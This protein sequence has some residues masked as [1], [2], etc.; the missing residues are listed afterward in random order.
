MASNVES[1]DAALRASLTA[2]SVTPSISTHLAAAEQY[3]RLGIL[4]RAVEHLQSG[5][6]LQPHNAAVNDALARVWRDFGLP[7]MGLSHAY[8][9]VYAEPRSATAR[10]TLG[11]LLYALGKRADAERAFRD[12]VDLD[13][14]AWYAWQNLCQ[15]AM[16]GG[17][18]QEAIDL[19]HHAIKLRRD[20]AK[21]NRP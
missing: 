18:T 7:G 8:R 10:H 11:T 15:V 1:V 3:R 21:A 2:V 5:E 17:R 14:A 20:R 13:P 6:R 4:D 9:A 12:A 16:V 19:C